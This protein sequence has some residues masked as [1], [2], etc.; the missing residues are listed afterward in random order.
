MSIPNHSF[1]R[2]LCPA[3]AAVQAAALGLGLLLCAASAARAAKWNPVPAADLAAKESMAFPGA[4]AEILL[5]EHEVESSTT[6]FSSGVAAG[7][8]AFGGARSMTDT[9]SWHRV[10]AKV[11]TARGVTDLGKVRVGDENFGAVSSVEAR[12]VKPDGRS[13]ELGKADIFD[14]KSG[15]A[16]SNLATIVFPGLGPGDVVEYRWRQQVDRIPAYGLLLI[17]CPM[18]VREYRFTV[19][20]LPVD[21]SIL[22]GNCPGVEQERIGEG[23][24]LTIRGLPAFRPEMLMPPL[25]ETKAWL[26]VV[27]RNRN[28]LSKDPLPGYSAEWANEFETATKPNAEMEKFAGEIVAGAANEEERLRRIF[29][30]CQTQIVNY[31]ESLNYQSFDPSQKRARLEKLNELARRRAGNRA[32]AVRRA[33]AERAGGSREINLVFAMLARAAGFE[34]AQMRHAGT[35]LFTHIREEGGWAFLTRDCVAV[36]LGGQWRY[37]APCEYWSTFDRLDLADA[38]AGSLRCAKVDKVELCTLPIA[39]AE[40][41]Q[42]NR[43]A[44]L[45]LDREGT[46]TGAVEES[47][48]GYLATELRRRQSWGPGREK[49]TTEEAYRRDLSRRLRGAEISDVVFDNLAGRTE[50]LLV[51]YRVRIPAFAR[52]SGARLVLAPSFFEVGR[53]VVLFGPRERNYPIVFPYAKQEHDDVEIELPEGFDLDNP[54]AP[55]AVGDGAKGLGCSYHVQFDRR[56]R[57]LAYRRD[58]VLGGNG[59]TTFHVESYVPVKRLFEQLSASDAHALVIKPKEPAGAS[60]P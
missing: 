16:P 2:A 9:V 38:G 23:V 60:T 22:W 37:F 30:F 21:C 57:V 50:P 53:P 28:H 40:A 54:S 15:G 45:I 4:D 39:P 32:A 27:V 20:R 29:D 24:R 18:P 56:S 48:T 7:T 42:A 59:I 46:L 44:R 58:F 8:R 34:V 25:Y 49:L 55:V 11:H 52:K 26:C 47:F 33:L 5:S 12:V 31:A 17:E 3:P 43:K 36:R 51:R 10:R 35:F 6:I 13:R 1:L 41:S 19:K 14:G